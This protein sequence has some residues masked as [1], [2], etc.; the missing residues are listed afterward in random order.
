[1]PQFMKRAEIVGVLL[2]AAFTL[3]ACGD[4][5]TIEGT[6]AEY[7]TVE[8]RRIEVRVGATGVPDE[9]RLLAVRDSI[10]IDPD[11]ENERRRGREA[12]RRFMELT[13]KGRPYDVLD[14][15]LVEQLNLFVRFKCRF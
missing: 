14:E 8:G 11:P 10:V 15:R 1:M 13:C 5:R 12:A 3:A 2:A 7:A 9:Y 4:Q 6:R